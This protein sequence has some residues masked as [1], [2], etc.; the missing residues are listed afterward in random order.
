VYA[1][2]SGDGEKL[3]NDRK[4]NF[5]K[6]LLTFATFITLAGTAT[7]QDA[8]SV[9]K[10]DALVWKEHAVFKGALIATLIGDPSKA[11]VV[12]QRVK[13]P[14]NFKIPPH[15]HSYSEVVTV[16]SGNYGNAMGKEKG[17]V[18]KPGSVFALPAGHVHHTWTQSEEVLVQVNFVGPANI[19]FVNPADD[20]RKK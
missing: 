6:R 17:E 10:P 8:M 3:G 11:E 9:V 2:A 7:A 15:T 5:M 19:T 14:P 16:L 20:P 18:L 13:I 4:E 12:V 1:A